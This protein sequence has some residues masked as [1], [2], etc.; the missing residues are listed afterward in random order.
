MTTIL[1]SNDDAKKLVGLLLDTCLDIE[2][3]MSAIHRG[4]AVAIFG[5]KE[6]LENKLLTYKCIAKRIQ[7]ELITQN[8]L[9]LAKADLKGLPVGTR[10]YIARPNDN[11]D[12]VR[13]CKITKHVGSNEEFL[14][15]HD[16]LHNSMEFS[17]DASN[18]WTAYLLNKELVNY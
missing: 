12:F 15:V 1:F 13:Y 6:R 5:E 14:M 8:S 18:Y 2:E 7:R 4:D 9:K 3:K 17:F 10:L 11:G 16:M